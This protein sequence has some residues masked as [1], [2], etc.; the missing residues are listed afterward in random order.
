[1]TATRYVKHVSFDDLVP[2]LIDDQVEILKHSQKH[3]GF[4]NKFLHVPPQYNPLYQSDS[5]QPKKKQELFTQNRSG[6][7]RRS[8]EH[9]KLEKVLQFMSPHQTIRPSLSS[10]DVVDRS[11]SSSPLAHCRTNPRLPPPPK[12]PSLKWSAK[13]ADEQ[14]R[15][16]DWDIYDMDFATERKLTKETEK[17]TQSNSGSRDGYTQAAF[18]N[19]NE[20]EDR[21]GSKSKPAA[22]EGSGG[23]KKSF[24]GMTDKELAELEKFYESQSR[25]T[26]SPT[27]DCYDFKEQDPFFIGKFDK[28]GGSQVADPLAAIY[29]SRPVVDHRAICVTIQ[30]PT[31]DQYV[32]GLNTETKSRKPEESLAAI[33][34]VSC[35]ISGRRYTWSSVDW[36]V[37]NCA[38]DGDH[39]IIVTSIPFFEREIESSDYAL[40]RR[41]FAESH[42]PE[43]GSFDEIDRG[44]RRVSTSSSETCKATTLGQVS[45][46]F[47]IKAVHDEAR[48]KC[49]N[50]LNYY[51]S[52]LQGIV[53]KITIEMIK[54]DSPE[55]AITK[56]AALYRPEIQ[57]VSTVSTNLQIKFRNGRV[58]LPFF[59][60]QHYPMSTAVVPYEFIDPRLLGE[61]PRDMTDT[62]K[63]RK[64]QIP[65]RNDRLVAIDSIIL[66]SLRNPFAADV[67]TT[68]KYEEDNDSLVESVNEY[69][70]MP[71]EQKRK[72][73]LFER[74]GYVRCL[75]TRQAVY[76]KNSN[77][78]INE[79]DRRSTPFSTAS[80][81][82]RS[83]R[84]QYDD[85]MYKVKSLIID[86]SES[87]DD[88]SDQKR[89]GSSIRKTRSMG[90]PARSGHVSPGLSPTTSDR[91]PHFNNVM[92]PT[93]SK[94]PE[95]ASP[96]SESKNKKDNKGREKKKTFG[97]FFRKV[98]K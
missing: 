51:A 5:E 66:K 13:R 36:Y 78:T 31:Y 62:L 11:R 29:P 69:F 48:Q 74:M 7:R 94:S 95:H 53:M 49:L 81:S 83:S 61:S 6:E 32:H 34:S 14:E 27:I 71:P 45:K 55:Y 50:I 92:H 52:R 80:N 17:N 89:H 57:I 19:L 18:A 43:Y 35:Y 54:C 86:S 28:K 41:Y 15:I 91:K 24:A 67:T 85:G 88:E 73:E 68:K 72:Y 97:S 10:P 58:K 1:M 16:I 40:N 96:A 44:L 38:R 39:L 64:E 21:L 12:T 87:S 65:R 4:N 25:S 90:P 42:G 75:P 30:H 46:G 47:R 63:E 2:T 37:E 98:F 59:V 8:D 23:R 22:K 26:A 3:A 56:A 60:M 20:L 79:D 84:I 9:D 77:P 33:R 76:I 70:P 82:R 93:S